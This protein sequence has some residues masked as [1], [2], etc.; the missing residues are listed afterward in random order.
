[1]N[2]SLPLG[3]L[4]AQKKMR[5]NP[6][7]KQFLFETLAHLTTLDAK[8]R[9]EYIRKQI[10]HELSHVKKKSL[11]CK[12]GCAHCC[13]HIINV[14]EAEAF[15]L[16]QVEDNA[17]L[18][19]QVQSL[20]DWGSLTKLQ[21]RCLYLSE[22]DSCQVYAQR[23]LVCRTTLVTSA[24]ENCDLEGNAE[25]TPYYV[26]RA[27]LL[28]MAYYSLEENAPLPQVLKKLKHVRA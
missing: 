13:H 10:D 15:S 27:Y 8:N 24:A 16:P 12:T 11:S 3:A 5:T 9:I 22:N 14:S 23:P 25:I 28:L 19:L 26:D 17:K 4:I 21:K 6:E 7:L 18:L 20:K 1:M 2:R